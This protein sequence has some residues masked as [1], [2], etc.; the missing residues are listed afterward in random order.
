MA[1]Y[2]FFLSRRSGPFAAVVN[3]ANKRIGRRLKKTFASSRSGDTGTLLEVGVGIGDMY[4]HLSS[5]DGYE[6]VGLDGSMA[7]CRSSEPGA[8]RI[9]CALLP[10]LPV[11]TGS[12]DVIYFSHVIEHL[13]DYPTV[14]KTLEN[15]RRALSPSGS[16][17][18][19]FPDYASWGSDFFEIDYTHNF[20]MG[21]RRMR[22]LAADAGF[23]IEWWTD[24]CGPYLGFMGR[25][26]GALGRLL[27]L[28]PAA[29]AFPRTLGRLRQSSYVFDRNLLCVL[30]KV[31][32]ATSE[33]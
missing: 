7:V 5:V 13:F 6:Y 30:R 9:I 26:F 23:D 24:Y 10:D 33:S 3:A 16:L 28:R 17:V 2:R 12:V 29:A 4:P 32:G 21:L 19:L 20:P 22:Q 8:R 25:V 31:P 15:M 27:P 18:V 14:L 11:R 1:F